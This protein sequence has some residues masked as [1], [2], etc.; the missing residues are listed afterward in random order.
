MILLLLFKLYFCICNLIQNSIYKK[1]TIKD[2][3]PNQLVKN[4]INS[5][6]FFYFLEKDVNNIFKQSLVLINNRKNNLTSNNNLQSKTSKLYSKFINNAYI[7]LYSIERILNILIIELG[8]QVNEL[9]KHN[10]CIITFLRDKSDLIFKLKKH[11]N[12]I[13]CIIEQTN[14]HF[15][16]QTK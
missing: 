5:K 13:L 3:M 10:S 2:Q 8:F 7:L 6:I 1:L 14:K 16:V 4:Y 11:K 9:N 12:K 15:I